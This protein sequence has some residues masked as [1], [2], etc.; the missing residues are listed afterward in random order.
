MTFSLN[1]IQVIVVT[2]LKET[3]AKQKN[4]RLIQKFSTIDK[5]PIADDIN[6]LENNGFVP[7]ALQ[8]IQFQSRQ[9][10]Q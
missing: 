3:K 5:F 1:N 7:I 9:N 6:N 2:R 8:N 10:K 4:K